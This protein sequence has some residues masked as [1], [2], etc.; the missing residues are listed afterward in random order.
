PC[1]GT[2]GRARPGS[3]ATS[4]PTPSAGGPAVPRL[5]PLR[6]PHRAGEREVRGPGRRR[7]YPSDRP[8]VRTVGADRPPAED[9]CIQA[10]GRAAPP[11]GPVRPGGPLARA[12]DARRTPCRTG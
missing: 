12:V 9:P 5:P 11:G 7:G 3:R 2:G 6:R 1:V 4:R 10:L 8:G